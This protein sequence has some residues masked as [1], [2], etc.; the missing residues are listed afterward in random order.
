MVKNDQIN[1]KNLDDDYDDNIKTIN[2]IQLKIR[3]F[4]RKSKEDMILPFFTA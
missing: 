1:N 3:Q 4:I 2:Y